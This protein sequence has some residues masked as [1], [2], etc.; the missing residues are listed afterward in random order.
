[1]GFLSPRWCKANA[2]DLDR[3]GQLR[4]FR[5]RAKTFLPCA[6][7]VSRRFPILELRW[8]WCTAVFATEWTFLH[9]RHVV[10]ADSVPFRSVKRS[11]SF[12]KPYIVDPTCFCSDI[13]LLIVFVFPRIEPV[14]P[15][16]H[17]LPCS[18]SLTTMAASPRALSLL[19][20][21]M[22]LSSMCLQVAADS[23]IQNV[24]S[25]DMKVNGKVL[26]RMEILTLRLVKRQTATI[27]VEFAAKVSH[28]VIKNRRQLFV[29]DNQFNTVDFGDGKIY[30]T[31]D[32]VEA[33]LVANSF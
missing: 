29:V 16:V 28:I 1:M 31:L 17:H 18:Y 3:P 9:R 30:K 25:V 21:T 27:T 15:S 8:C 26:K 24:S 14:A 11:V 12:P 7:M 22:L 19:L 6:V 10:S 23:T 13:S 33:R 32:L 4:E 5:Y 20:L 2:G